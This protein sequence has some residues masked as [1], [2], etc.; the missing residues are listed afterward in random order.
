LRKITYEDKAYYGFRHPVGWERESKTTAEKNQERKNGA[1]TKHLA[2][3]ISH[4][5]P[6]LQNPGKFCFF[7]PSLCRKEMALWGMQI[8]ESRVMARIR[9]R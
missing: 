9:E 7:P 5:R 6:S 1:E 3:E 4:I 8:N 2:A